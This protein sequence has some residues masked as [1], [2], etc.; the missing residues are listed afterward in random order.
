ME[1]NYFNASLHIRGVAPRCR[2][3]AFTTVDIEREVPLEHDENTLKALLLKAKNEMSKF[4]SVSLAELVL[5]FTTQDGQF[6]SMM[7]F[8]ER[9]KKHNLLTQGS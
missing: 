5:T 3:A 7:L 9:H 4:K 1:R 8:D 6:E 2:K